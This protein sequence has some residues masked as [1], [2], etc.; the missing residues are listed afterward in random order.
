MDTNILDAHWPNTY[1]N[2]STHIKLCEVTMNMILAIPVSL[3]EI[4][5]NLCS[6]T[7]LT[8]DGVLQKG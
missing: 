5:P 6:E 3:D 4:S 2:W 7:K 1:T 8:V